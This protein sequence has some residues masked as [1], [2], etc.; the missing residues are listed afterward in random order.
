MKRSLTKGE[1][2]TRKSDFERVFAAGERRS[3]SGARLVYKKNGL[4]WNRFAVCPV[5]K[6]GDA[7]HRNRAKRLGKEAYRHIKDRLKPGY[8][9]VMV[10]YPG[11]DTFGNR[12]S[13]LESLLKKAG[14]L[15]NAD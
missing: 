4:P 10:V 8:D 1:R 7:V 11:T 9:L 3:C 12:Y 6:Y 14:L 2:L 13:Q 15:R 5:R